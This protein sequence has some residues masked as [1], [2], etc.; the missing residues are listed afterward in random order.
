MD[1]AEQAHLVDLDLVDYLEDLA[2]QDELVP[3]EETASLDLL[4]CIL[5]LVLNQ[6]SSWK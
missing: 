4:V 2:L 5:L 3:L 1:L 6:V